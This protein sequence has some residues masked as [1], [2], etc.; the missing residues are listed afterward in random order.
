MST[1]CGHNDITLV[2][3]IDDIENSKYLTA[4][5]KYH[6]LHRPCG[7]NLTSCDCLGVGQLTYAIET[8]QSKI[9]LML[10]RCKSVS[11]AHNLL[12]GKSESEWIFGSKH[13][14]VDTWYKLNVDSLSLRLRAS[15]TD[16]SV[17]DHIVVMREIDL[18]HEWVPLC[19]ESKILSQL[20]MLTIKPN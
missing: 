12:Q 9:E 10:S 14:G 13:F 20:G 18:L 2:D 7:S 17:F 6:T 1:L 15:Q 16:V 4:A 3:V 8:F 11:T 19:Y 5:T